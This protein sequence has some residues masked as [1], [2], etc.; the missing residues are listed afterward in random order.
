MCCQ[1]SV[2][3][4]SRA[5]C[6]KKAAAAASFSAVSSPSLLLADAQVLYAA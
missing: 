2:N 6:S 5:S 4:A 1:F 3:P